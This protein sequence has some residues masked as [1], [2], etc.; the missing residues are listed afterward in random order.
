MARRDLRFMHIWMQQD[1]LFFKYSVRLEFVCFLWMN[2]ASILNV[3]DSFSWRVIRGLGKTMQPR[4]RWHAAMYRG[5]RRWEMAVSRCA[6]I[7]VPKKEERIGQF[8]IAIEETEISVERTEVD[9]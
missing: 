6:K 7:N 4:L 3:E 5:E 1:A 9:R 2:K 8:G